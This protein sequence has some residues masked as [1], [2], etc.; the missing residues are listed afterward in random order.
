[1]VPPIKTSRS[2][3]RLC[4]DV[5]KCSS[6]TAG[7]MDVEAKNKKVVVLRTKEHEER[8]DLNTAAREINRIDV[9]P[10]SA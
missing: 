5:S 8:S 6:T 9:T 7:P 2:V 10:A 3:C 4:G 1:M